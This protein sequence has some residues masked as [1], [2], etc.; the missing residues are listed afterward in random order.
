MRRTYY[1]PDNDPLAEFLD[2]LPR[3]TRSKYFRLMLREGIKHL[4]DIPEQVKE[5]V[6]CFHGWE[7]ATRQVKEV[8][9]SSMLPRIQRDILQARREAMTKEQVFALI[10]ARRRQAYWIKNKQIYDL[11]IDILNDLHHGVPLYAIQQKTGI[12]LGELSSLGYGRYNHE[13]RGEQL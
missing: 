5:D 4:P 11:T 7:A 12:P 2:G 3:G 13:S 1:F 10:R 9:R 8:Y 6:E